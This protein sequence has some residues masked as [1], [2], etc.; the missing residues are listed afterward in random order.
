MT[1]QSITFS[2]ATMAESSF[3]IFEAQLAPYQEQ[4]AMEE[5]TR[6]YLFMRDVE[7]YNES[8]DLS[9]DDWNILLKVSQRYKVV[10]RKMSIKSMQPTAKLVQ[11]VD[12]AKFAQLTASMLIKYGQEVNQLNKDT[13]QQTLLQLTV[14]G[15]RLLLQKMIPQL[16]LEEEETITNWQQI[17]DKDP[18]LLYKMYKPIF[19]HMPNQEH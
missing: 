12:T 8:G 10:Q 15:R 9:V 13:L 14:D 3:P 11:H 4:V 17:A 5:S 7:F 1:F 19:D 16:N 18:Q 2:G 6:F